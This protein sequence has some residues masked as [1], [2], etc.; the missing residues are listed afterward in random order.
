[1]GGT[2]EK[3]I[4]L[5][6]SV[7]IGHHLERDGR[8]VAVGLLAEET[9]A[10]EAVEA[11][12]PIA[13]NSYSCRSWPS[14]SLDFEVDT[15]VEHAAAEQIALAAAWRKVEEVAF[16]GKA[17]IVAEEAAEFARNSAGSWRGSR[18]GSVMRC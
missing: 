7:E 11:A 14:P 15:P 3:K 9:L 5:S 18:R 4:P 8:Q 6:K 2:L 17:G 16:E 10:V 12:E 1:M 13:A